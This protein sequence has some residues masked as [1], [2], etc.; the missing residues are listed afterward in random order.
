MREQKVKAALEEESV[1]TPTYASRE[2]T[3][4]I[5]KHA[6]PKQSTAP[7]TVYN[8][9]H[10][11]LIMDGNSRQNL[12][13][14]VTTW[15]EPEAKK[16]MSECF[17]KNMIDKDEYPQTAEIESRC[18]NMLAN[19]WN[20]PDHETAT[21]TSTIGSSEAAMLGGMAMKWNWRDKMKKAGKPT[22]KPN[23]VMGAN[24]QICWHKFCK[25]WDI[26]AREVKSEGN[27]FT[28]NAEEALKLVDENTI[29][30]VVIMGSTMDGK[31]EPVKEVA[32][33]LD[34][35]QQQTGIDIPIHVDGAS[36]AFIAP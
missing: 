14:F 34:T 24:T 7:E 32:D 26:D 13:T 18:I 28:L 5:P 33:A 12:A 20:S 25:Y 4:S 19:L 35:Y 16:L 36:G 22:N 10:D 23:M 15:M 3:E 8:L 1:L 27:R 6:I 31:Y 21:G 29:G 17:D 9:I 30:V 2:M 11:E